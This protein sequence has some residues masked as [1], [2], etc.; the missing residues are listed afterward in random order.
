MIRDSNLTNILCICGWL[1]IIFPCWHKK[2]GLHDSE[3][4]SKGTRLYKLHVHAHV[5]NIYLQE[6]FIWEQ[7]S[8][9][10]TCKIGTPNKG[11]K[12]GGMKSFVT[13]PLTPSFSG[14]QVSA[15]IRDGNEEPRE[16]S[17]SREIGS[18]TQRSYMTGDLVSSVLKPPFPYDN[19]VG[20]PILCL[21]TMSFTP[22][23]H[24]VLNVKVLI[25]TFNQEKA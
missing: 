6:F 10:Y 18:P 8:D 13:Y 22:A 4:K 15:V 25:G 7:S 11:S 17:K 21:L 23:Y 16:G 9:A 5:K 3:Q 24:S 14:I 12:F 19:W 1:L 2:I 20:I